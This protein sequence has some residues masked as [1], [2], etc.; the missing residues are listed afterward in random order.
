MPLI[1]CTSCAYANA[2][3]AKVC[4]RCGTALRVPPPHLMRCAHCGSLNPLD[5]TICVWCYRKLPARR[6]VWQG[7]PVR[8]AAA[9]AVALLAALGYYAYPR[10][11]PQDAPGPVIAAPA[12]A[13]ETPA[14]EPPRPAEVPRAERQPGETARAKAAPAA[15][16]RQA[17]N[18]RERGEPGAGN[19]AEGVAAL[20]LCGK[21]E[22][23]Q[24]PRPQ[25]CTE[26]VAALGLCE[27]SN[28]Q[29]RE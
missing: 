18:A 5:G 28:I 16:A 7:W 22:V 4:K 25:A 14:A 29:G 24:P 20:G 23:R 19:C 11:L 12:P 10:G 3:D 9:A 27:S 17:G 2:A 26:A 15:V 8:G 21:K 1:R 6:R 13:P